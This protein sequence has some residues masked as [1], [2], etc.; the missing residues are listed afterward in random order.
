MVAS[1]WPNPPGRL[2]AVLRRCRISSEVRYSRGR[3]AALVGRRGVVVRFSMVGPS[4]AFTRKPLFLIGAVYP[5]VRISATNGLSHLR[6]SGLIG[7][8]TFLR[9]AW[10][11]SGGACG[12]RDTASGAILLA[13]WRPGGA[14][15]ALPPSDQSLFYLDLCMGS[16]VIVLLTTWFW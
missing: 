16:L 5:I 3:T 7:G 10:A 14:W 8:R 9:G 11:N 6:W 1:R 15:E 2:R 13:V 4:F 12:A